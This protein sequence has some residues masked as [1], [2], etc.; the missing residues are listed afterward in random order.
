MA[1]GVSVPASQ[2]A[3]L[4]VIGTDKNASLLSSVIKCFVVVVVV[5]SC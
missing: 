3:P 2:F 1:T 4:C 5:V